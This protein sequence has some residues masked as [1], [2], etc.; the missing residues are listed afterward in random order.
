MNHTVNYVIFVSIFIITITIGTMW[1]MWTQDQHINELKYNEIVLLMSMH[2]HCYGS[3]TL[4]VADA[5]M[6][7]QETKRQSEQRVV[8]IRRH[9][10]AIAQKVGM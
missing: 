6:V 7:C 1:A 5:K 10:E 2:E 8:D 4:V 9:R 3:Y